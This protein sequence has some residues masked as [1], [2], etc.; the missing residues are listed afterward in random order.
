MTD[1][2]SMEAY[3]GRLSQAAQKANASADIQ[4]QVVHGTKDTDVLTENGLVPSLAK[5]AVQAQVKVSAA[6]E[7]V[8]AQ[9]AGAMTY[10]TKAAG[11]AATVSGGFFSV[12]SDSAAEY[13]ILY[14]N[15]AG[16]ATELKRYPSAERFSALTELINELASQTEYLNV[17]TEEGEAVLTLNGT[18]LHTLGFSVGSTASPSVIGDEEG[19][20]LLYADDEGI[21]LGPL[22]FRYT[23]G[24]GIYVVNE[25][26][27][28]LNA[29]SDP[30]SEAEASE[31]AV[32][33]EGGLLFHPTLAV[34]EQG[35]IAIHLHNILVHRERAQSVVAS[36]DSMTTSA[37]S[38]GQALRIKGGRFGDSA[39]LRLRAV[40]S[41]DIRLSMPLKLMNVPTQ[42]PVKP[43]KVLIIGDSIT[44]RQGA[45]LLKEYLGKL[46]FNATMVGTLRGSGDPTNN[47]DMNGEYGEG[48]EGWETGDFT[49]DITDRLQIVPPGTEADY[50]A[51]SKIEKQRKNP[52]VRAATGADPAEIVR[53]GYVFDPAF[54]Q[55]RFSLETPDIV[56][57]ALGTNNVRD[58]TAETIAD[59]IYADDLLIYKQLHATW[60]NARVVRS[61]PGTA[62][63]TARNALWI[64]HYAP[65]IRAMRR[66]IADYGNSKVYLAPTW[67]HVS[68]EAGFPVSTAVADGDGF[69][70]GNFLNLVHPEGAGRHG[71]YESLAAYVAA[72]A[73]HLNE[74]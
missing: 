65:M 13:L 26:G 36:L 64:S 24:N 31:S 37:I 67:A 9:M 18:H 44:N 12:P 55:S 69:I 1:V 71:L 5:Q 47:E 21:Q 39:A 29:L 20:T 74:Q 57:N 19:A 14:R 72:A 45:Q 28:L 70:S 35:E 68:S 41:L 61:L 46:G 48:R 49:A 62:L 59:Q 11:L 10:A 4:H 40:D 51:M 33:F 38:E 7:Q 30:L 6:L 66:A 8:A 53:N 16:S 43:V 54:Y 50:M 73:L 52:F 58:R 42:N 2:S 3:A 56:I 17:R 60:P 63:G 23:D 25:E 22:A 34:P 27:E 32:P 15:D